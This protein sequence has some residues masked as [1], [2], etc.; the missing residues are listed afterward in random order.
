MYWTNK[1]NV[2]KANHSNGDHEVTAQT[3]RELDAFDLAC[4]RK[5][6]EHF[7]STG[8]VQLSSLEHIH[9]RME[10]SSGVGAGWAGSDVVNL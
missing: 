3:Q 4:L 1:L 6:S 10:E 8:L 2:S 9:S 7:F 5:L